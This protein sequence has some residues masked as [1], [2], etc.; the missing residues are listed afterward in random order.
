M[1][2]AGFAVFQSTITLLYSLTIEQCSDALKNSKPWTPCRKARVKLE[3]CD[4][5]ATDM[6]P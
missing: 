6:L 5:K 1:L 4:S 3:K 2:Y